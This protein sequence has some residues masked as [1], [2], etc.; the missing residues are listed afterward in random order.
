MNNAA[1]DFNILMTFLMFILWI[2]LSCIV[3]GFLLKSKKSKKLLTT[4]YLIS[5]IVGGILL[6]GIPNAVMPIQHLI[7]V[8][9]GEPA[10]FILIPMLLVLI[11]LL[12]TTLLIGRVFCGYACPVGALQELSSRALYKSKPRKDDSLIYKINPPNKVSMIIRWVMFVIFF[13]TIIIWNFLLLQLINPFLG[14]YFLLHS[15]ELIILIPLISLIIIFGLSFF[16]YRP[17]CRFLCPFGALASLT[18]RYSRLKLKRTE[19]CTE[20][21]LCEQVCPT[22][23]AFRESSKSE[24]YLCNR[25]VEI[26]PQEAIKFK[27][28]N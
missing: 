18:S 28:K 11:T 22:Q 27:T 19:A 3:L 14:F 24:C 8:L 2:V 10:A 17:W 20:C 6:G 13:A 15:T 23:E 12:L 9:G 1:P 5:I 25:C 26:C 7:V 16:V 21:H 4:L